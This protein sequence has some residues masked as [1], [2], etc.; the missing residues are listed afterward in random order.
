VIVSEVYAN[1]PAAKAGV[2]PYDVITEI[3]GKRIV[4]GRQL[5]GTITSFGP[6]TKIDI[7]VLRSGKERDFKVTVGKRPTKDTML[8]QKRP[9]R[10][11][12]TQPSMDLGMSVEDLDGELRRELNLPSG[13]KGVVVSRVTPGG[14][15]ED[16]GFERGDLIVEVDQ[17]PV[18]SVKAF[19]A[20]FR[21]RKVYLIRFRRGDD[22]LA[23]TSLDLSKAQRGNSADEEGED[24]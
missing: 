8:S 23:I 14:P 11:R 24:E 12:G 4:D 15:A 16:A 2:E 3:N 20:A 1:E 17:K 18:P 6:G 9:R 10:G 21:A 22:G 19:N 13:S 5:V 7:K